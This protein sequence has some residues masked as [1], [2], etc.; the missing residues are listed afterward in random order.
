MEILGEPDLSEEES[1][2][3]SEVSV[4]ASIA[5]ATTPLGTNSTYP[6]KT[7][8]KKDPAKHAARAFARAKR[9]KI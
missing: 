4:A 6:K 9:V 2:Q 8:K 7:K 3:E 5:G 1:D